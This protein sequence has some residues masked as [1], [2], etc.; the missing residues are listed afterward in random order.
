[1]TR[2]NKGK[3]RGKK[4]R[5][6]H[7]HSEHQAQEDVVQHSASVLSCATEAADEMAAVC[8]QHVQNL[9]IDVPYV[10]LAV[11]IWAEHPDTAQPLRSALEELLQA[12]SQQLQIIKDIQQQL[13]RLAAD[14]SPHIHLDPI[15]RYRQLVRERLFPE[16]PVT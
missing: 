6:K 8:D 16:P 13:Q 11:E 7:G 4:A 5:A 12:F 9:T 10:R 2:R 15:E 3:G 1:M 14:P